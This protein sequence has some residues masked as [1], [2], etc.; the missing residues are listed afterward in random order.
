MGRSKPKSFR[1]AASTSGDALRPAIR[2]E[3]SDPGVAK[4]IR[5][6]MT[7]IPNITKIIWI[8]RRMSVFS[9]GR[10]VASDPKLGARIQRVANTVTQDVQGQHRDRDGDARRECHHRPR[11]EQ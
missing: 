2:D 1:T 10:S 4:K 6:T 8:R 5:K 9:I 11:I 7:L 3:G